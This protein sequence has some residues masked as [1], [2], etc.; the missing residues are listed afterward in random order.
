MH[1]RRY[2]LEESLDLVTWLEDMQFTASGHELAVYRP[3]AGP[4]KFWRVGLL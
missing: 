1:G 3:L 4:Q 2:V